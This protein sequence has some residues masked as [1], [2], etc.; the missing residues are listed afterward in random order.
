[1]RLT[2]ISSPTMRINAECLTPE[3]CNKLSKKQLARQTLPSSEGEIAIGDLFKIEED[4]SKSLLISGNCEQFDYIGAKVKESQLKVEGSVGDYAAATLSGG[5]L[6]I[7]GDVGHYAAC[8]MS[9]GTVIIEGNAGD[10]TGGASIG[11]V[12]GM[13]GGTVLVLGDAGD[14]TANLM[15]RGLVVVRGNNGNYGAAHMKAGNLVVLKQNGNHCAYGMQR[16]TVLLN[17]ASSTEKLGNT[18]ISQPYNY[19]MDFLI[20]LYKHISQLAPTL[21]NLPRK[22][23]IQRYIGDLAVGGKGEVLVPYA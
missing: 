8:G 23:L 3:Y 6:E 21:Q 10:A 13:S 7:T 22:K 9:G 20:L 5:Q 18:F 17:D 12:Q 15:R 1:M 19:N 14:R 16:G 11:A 4:S 2:L